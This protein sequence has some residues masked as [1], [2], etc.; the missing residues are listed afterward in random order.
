MPPGAWHLRHR[1][2]TYAAKSTR[3]AREI[4]RA[5]PTGGNT[6]PIVLPLAW[7]AMATDLPGPL[8]DPRCCETQR[9]RT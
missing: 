3:M 1:T 8:V 4:H 6:S 5:A 9:C 7:K 2:A